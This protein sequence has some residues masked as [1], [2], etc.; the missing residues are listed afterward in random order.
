MGFEPLVWYCRPVANGVWA[1][2]VE[3][4]FGAYTPCATDTLVV[5]ISNLVLMGLCLYRIWLTKKDFTVQRFRLRSNYYNYM[6][7]LLAAYCTAEPLFRLVMGI[8]ALNLDGQT[9]GL[10]PFEMVSLIIEAFAWCSMV[11]M[12]GVETKVYISK[13]RWYIGFG[14][15]YAL[16]GDI[17]MLSLI[18]PVKEFYSRTVE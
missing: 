18:L 9:G 15:I 4:A 1:R 3:N 11:V 14:V 7:V 13:F 10:A 6:L 8:S 5:S 16:V 2:V 12:L 17:V